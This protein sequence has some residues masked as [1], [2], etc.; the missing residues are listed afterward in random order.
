MDLLFVSEHRTPPI[1]GRPLDSSI[2]G[3][4]TKTTQNLSEPGGG[5]GS[6]R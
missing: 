5:G 1:G 3:H 6:D 2:F 4:S